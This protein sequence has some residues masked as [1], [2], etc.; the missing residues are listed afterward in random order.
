[1]VIVEISRS[2]DL[3]DDSRERMIL[4]AY[5]LGRQ[6]MSSISEQLHYS[7]QHTYRLRDSGE[8]KMRKMRNGTVI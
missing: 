7:L 1:M 8:R 4:D 5:Y 6:S 2:I 3:L